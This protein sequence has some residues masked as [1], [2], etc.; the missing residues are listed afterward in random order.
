VRFNKDSSIYGV[1]WWELYNTIQAK[2]K[3]TT[4]FGATFASKFFFSQ[5]LFYK[6]FGNVEVFG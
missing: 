6:L 5:S 2:K 3:E 4:N 1:V